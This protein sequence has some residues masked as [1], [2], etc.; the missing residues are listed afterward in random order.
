MTFPPLSEQNCSNCR[1][2]RIS[3]AW[4]GDLYCHC[5]PPQIGPRGEQWPQ[6]DRSEWCG[7]WVAREGE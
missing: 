4:P 6:V 2:C 7:E 1:Y 3:T 5:N